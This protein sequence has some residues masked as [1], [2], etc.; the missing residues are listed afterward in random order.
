MIDRLC[1]CGHPQSG[2]GGAVFEC[3]C[4][5][6]IDDTFNGCACEKFEDE[7]T[8]LSSV[9]P[10]IKPIQNIDTTATTTTHDPVSAPSH[11]T[12]FPNGVQPIDLLEH[13]PF[14]LGAAGKYILRAGYKGPALEDIKKAIWFLERELKRVSK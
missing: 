5:C 1:Q 10:W 14:N 6:V 12:R 2:H 8:T 4:I 11:Y 13:L 3:K 9:A 7:A